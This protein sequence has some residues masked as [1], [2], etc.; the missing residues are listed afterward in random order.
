MEVRLP[1]NVQVEDTGLVQLRVFR[2]GIGKLFS[3]F[4]QVRS[5]NVA[6]DLERR[7]TRKRPPRKSFLQNL[8]T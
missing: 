7:G 6:V 4:L 1:E 8:I 3:L 2:H 5:I